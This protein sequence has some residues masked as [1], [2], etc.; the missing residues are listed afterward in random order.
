M[1][2]MY[3]E[4]TKKLKEAI[5]EHNLRKI[6]T[7]S[8]SDVPNNRYTRTTGLCFD[9]NDLKKDLTEKKFVLVLNHFEQSAVC[10]TVWE[11][12]YLDFEAANKIY[13]KEHWRKLWDSSHMYYD[14]GKELI[15]LCL[16]KEELKC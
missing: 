5:N 4:P 2:N 7:G 6:Y 11:T 3:V 10:W 15:N 16:S 9:I 12:P 13:Q 1:K 14:D 8:L